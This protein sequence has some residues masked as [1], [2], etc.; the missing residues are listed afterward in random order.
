MD[1]NSYI[2]SSHLSKT[3]MHESHFQV[4]MQTLKNTKNK[5]SSDGSVA[6][7]TQTIDTTFP[8][9]G[10]VDAMLASI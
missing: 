3:Q 6:F 7:A 5:R 2:E 10:G 4:E 9:D 1:Q 8:A